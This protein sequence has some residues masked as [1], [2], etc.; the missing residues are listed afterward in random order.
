[1]TVDPTV[2]PGLLLLA[3]ELLA[4]AAVGFV[5]ARVALRQ[6][7]DGMA[8]AQGMVIGPA[9]WGLIVNFLL[10]LLPGRAGAAAGWIVLLS[11]A[12][13]LAWRAVR[14]PAL[15]EQK[16]DEGDKSRTDR[17]LP[18][19][20]RLSPHTLTGFLAAALAIFW[21]ALASRQ[22]LAIPDSNLHLGLVAQIQ[23]GGFPPA[24]PWTP[25]V[26]A[27]YHYGPD[28]L[29]GLLAPPFGPDLAFTTE[30]LGAYAWAS[31]ALAAGTLILSRGSWGGTLALAPLALTTGAWTI[32]FSGELS[33]L[34]FLTPTGL[35][36]AGIRASLADV[37][38]PSQQPSWPT[39]LAV[40]P[41][42]IWK[43]A[44]TLAYALALVTLERGTS[45]HGRGWLAVL[46]LAALIGFLGLVD[47][48]VAV[49]V[50]GLWPAVEIVRL[51]REGGLS[52]RPQADDAGRSRLWSR[53]SQADPR[54]IWTVAKPGL[55]RA[56]AGSGLA[57]VL[58]VVGGGAITGV[59]IDPV[60]SGLSLGWSD[61]VSLRRAL[62]V[63]ET[64]PGGIGM[65]GLGVVP[66][67]AAAA[68]AWRDRL[69]L[70]LVAGSGLLLL[71]AFT[72]QY[73]YGQHDVVR[74]DG[75]ARNF[76][77]LALLIALASRVH[78]LPP[79]WRY[80]AGALIVALI[81]WPT[82]AKPV[83]VLD[84]A[85]RAGP[86][87]EN[88]QV[89]QRLSDN[90]ELDRQA[91]QA[92]VA[93]TRVTNYIREHTAADDRVLSPDPTGI[94]VA[95]G[96]PNVS[97]LPQTLQ[98]AYFYGPDY[99]DA[100]RHLEPASVRRLGIAY[101][102]APD[103]WVADLPARAAGWLHDPR[104]FNLLVRDETD[105]LYGVRPAFLELGPAPD[106][107]SFEAL[108][109][110]IPAS[111]TVYLLPGIP[112]HTAMR[113]M[114][115][116]SHAQLLGFRQP[117]G[118]HVRTTFPEEPLGAHTP[119]FAVV[120]RQFTTWVYETTGDQPVWW[121][122][123][124][125]VYARNEA[126]SPVMDAWSQPKPVVDIRLSEVRSADSR[127]VF[128]A[129]LVNPAA[130]RWTGQDWLVIATDTSPWAL[131]SEFEAANTRVVAGRQ[132]FAGQATSSVG[133]LTR[134]YEY[135]ARAG[136]LATID[137]ADV[138]TLVAPASG[139]GLTPGVWTLAARVWLDRY[140]LDVELIPLLK[141]VI[142]T[143]GD[144]TYGVYTENGVNTDTAPK[145]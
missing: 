136:A 14:S 143:T 76:A 60:P 37:Y 104:L 116:L 71:A 113:M 130:G 2:L 132:W 120:S 3:L 79:R 4:L 54:A 114:S 98:F 65:L 121:N 41:A 70:T 110:A 118:L 57:V 95:T 73:E 68:L 128:T 19:A 32:V 39:R 141:I 61:D 51:L 77:L 91:I 6:S 100:I 29:I 117:P 83:R 38:W 119:E 131:P 21:I 42:N 47:E 25:D 89:G 135:D 106:P 48:I 74:L 96:R 7:N 107:A 24:F 142:A 9:L 111:A 44:F 31:L 69:V 109:Q 27:T 16:T 137:M 126:I 18:P 52:A 102:H 63:F 30:L 20:L 78:A 67:A 145:A 97:G 112:R 43:P 40:S 124:V 56:G 72:L 123:S 15:C 85:L 64:L 66:V 80:P 139:R 36:E 108:R 105:A 46:T 99:L 81:V 93:S 75:H 87:L 35:P 45:S 17:G 10:H 55:L 133:T 11:L 53:I 94:S 49:I 101:V 13:G 8:L 62:G 34:E 26:Q 28:L 88:A 138:R 122:E 23:A 22:L 33:I 103:A 140:N 84:W 5:V 50:V 59:L 1:M 12:A 144:V 92:S 127:V 134:K 90:V 115:A 86:H 82:V 58:L 125:A 129:A